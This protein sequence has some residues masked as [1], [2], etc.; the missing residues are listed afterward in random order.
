MRTLSGSVKFRRITPGIETLHSSFSLPRHRHLHAYATVVL[1]GTF[2][3][4]GY[5]GRIRATAG[6]V[7]IHPALDCHGNQMV[8][9]GVKLIRLDW[10]ARDGEGGLYCLDE[11]DA[12]ARA[13]ERD[14][15]AARLLLEG[16][17]RKGCS[18]SPNQKRDWPDQLAEALAQDSSLEIGTWAETNGLA[19]ET[20]SRGFTAAYG[21]APVVY[22]AEL[23]ART[24]WLHIT[25][26]SDGLSTIA[27]DAGFADQA[28]MT[29]WINRITGAPPAAWR[30]EPFV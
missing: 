3:E 7:L 24:A 1:A 18:S 22:R 28:H 5:I 8:S 4:A 16:A 25:R 6:D 12:F 21:I 2:E 27:A 23:R 10:H 11:V 13:A 30:R 29:R 17:L 20:V 19:R 9:A 14:V 15:V 26:R